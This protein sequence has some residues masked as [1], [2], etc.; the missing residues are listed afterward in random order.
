M[1]ITNGNTCTRCGKQRIVTSSYNETVGN[2]SITYTIT[3]CCDPECQ[4]MVDEKLLKEEKKRELFKDEQ[5][6]RI[7]LRKQSFTN[8]KKTRV[9]LV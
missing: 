2:S 3:A 5:E 4:K 1:A 7:Q 9:N 8:S 6:K